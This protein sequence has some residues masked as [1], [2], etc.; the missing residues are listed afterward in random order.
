MKKFFTLIFLIIL[1]LSILAGVAGYYLFSA[2][3]ARKLVEIVLAKRLG[4]EN[5]R[6]GEVKGT[7]AQTLVLTDVEF[8]NLPNFPPGSIFLANNIKVKNNILKTAGY[9]FT[10]NVGK[11]IIPK[12]ET[13]LLNGTYGQNALD[14][15]VYARKINIA[16]VISKLPVRLNMSGI[17]GFV[18][19]IDLVIKGSAKNPIVTGTLFLEEVKYNKFFLRDCPVT[20]DIKIKDLGDKPLFYGDVFLNSGTI[21]GHK[22]AIITLGRSKISFNGKGEDVLLEIN[23]KAQVEGIKIRIE[24]GGWIGA[25]KIQV[26]SIPR[27]PEEKILLMLVTAKAWA[28]S[29][30][31]FT[32]GKIS[33]A[34]AK[35]FIDYFLGDSGSKLAKSLGLK[36]INFEYDENSKS[37]GLKKTIND[38]TSLGYSAAQSNKKDEEK[39]IKHKV[40][41]EYNISEVISVE[42]ER[43]IDYKSTNVGNDDVPGS[44]SMIKF[45]KPF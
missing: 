38:N 4:E 42:V 32:S 26:S 13:I 35:E 37:V 7:I 23:G 27:I 1:P 21:Q 10:I 41:G 15:E 24:V 5:I 31:A 11:L 8:K 16:N 17:N 3:G 30:Q 19:E 6:I 36:E 12:M 45:K 9:L 29:E 34:A 22:T 43:G 39:K 40:S 28:G 18:N 14:L 20:L 2:Q 33:V 44:K 25:P